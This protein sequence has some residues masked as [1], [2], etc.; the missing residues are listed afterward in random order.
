MAE[1]LA[2]Y[3]DSV[4]HNS[5]YLLELSP[6][7][8][9]RIPPADLAAYSGFGAAL[10]RCYTGPAAAVAEVRDAVGPKVELPALGKAADRLLV[11]EDVAACGQRVTNYTLAGLAPGASA[12]VPLASGRS[13]GHG[14]IHRL[15]APVP[16]GTRVRLS[17]GAAVPGEGACA[18]VRVRRLAAFSHA[19]C[20]GDA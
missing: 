3:E 10:E 9:G 12:W 13:I 20:M 17:I 1:L 19:I 4:G 7:P 8:L 5:N 18:Q 16:A 15:A 6:D 14:R 11:A 2:E